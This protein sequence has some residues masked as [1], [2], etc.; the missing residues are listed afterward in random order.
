MPIRKGLARRTTDKPRT[1]P[2]NKAAA[3]A[4]SAT[5]SRRTSPRN[6]AAA[7]ATSEEKKQQQA[8]KDKDY[9]SIN[10]IVVKEERVVGK[11]K[12]TPKKN[13]DATF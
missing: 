1:S 12:I 13:L 9:H 8:A 2:R 6:K 11:K 4:T 5:S 7:G 3:G 10:A